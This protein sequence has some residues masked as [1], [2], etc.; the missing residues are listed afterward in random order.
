MPRKATTKKF[1]NGTTELEM[2][3]WRHNGFAGLPLGTVTEKTREMRSI[4]AFRQP[5]AAWLPVERAIRYRDAAIKHECDDRCT[6]GSP[7]GECFCQ[8][9]GRNHGRHFQCVAA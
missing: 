3:G 2:V 1:F 7:R 5:A 6:L 9:G 4:Q 8:C